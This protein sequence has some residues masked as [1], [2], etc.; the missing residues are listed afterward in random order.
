MG[1]ATIVMAGGPVGS[2]P[3]GHIA[4]AF[5]GQGT[6][7][8]GTSQPFGS[9]TTAYLANQASY[10]DTTIYLL[11]TT[12]GQEQTMI[13]T[14]KQNYTQKGQYSIVKHDCAT[15]VADA[16]SAAGI[17]NDYVNQVASQGG[18]PFAQIPYTPAFMAAS[19]PGT[20]TYQIP[21]GSTIPAYY[22]GFNQ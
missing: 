1:M 2:N 13:D 3:A 6:Y 19:F 9:S 11:P 10:R 4:I 7:S 5:T 14:I 17:G 22:Q 20:Q 12:P 8:Y 15:M 16:L 18:V 21:R